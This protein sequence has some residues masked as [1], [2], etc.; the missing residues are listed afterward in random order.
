MEKMKTDSKVRQ[1]LAKASHLYFFGIY[2]GEWA[3][4][5]TA[6]F[7]REIFQIT[8]NPDIPLAVIASFRGSAKSTIVTNSYPIWAIVGKPQKKFVVIASNTQRQARQHLANIKSMLEQNDLL[9]MDL[10]PFQ[11]QDEWGSYS[12]V[13]PQY[14]ARI[15]A[16]SSEQSI[17]GLRHGSSRPDLIIVDDV[18]DL[19]SV[20]TR[21]G[22]DKIY[23]WFS[24]DVIPA[25]E[26]FQT[27]IMVVGNL[28]HE[29][30]LIMRLKQSIK[31][32]RH[33][34]A[35]F[36]AYPLL[37]AAE[38]VAWPDKYKTSADIEL[39]RQIVGDDIAWQREFLLRIVADEG[40]IIKPEW[41]QYYDELP[42][43]KIQ[44]NHYRFAGVGVDLASSQNS[45][46]DY[47]AMVSGKVFGYDDRT[48]IYILPHP[49]NERMEFP[50][51]V[52][53]LKQL[54]SILDPSKKSRLFIEDVQYQASLVQELQSKNYPAEGVKVHGQDK[55]AR[56]VIISH[57][58]KQGVVKFPRKGCEQL[59][60]QL[61]GF[62]VEK[63]D[64]LADAFAIL[65]NQ[66]MIGN[67]KKMAM[68]EVWFCSRS[69]DSDLE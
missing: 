13:L 58:L 52:E 64:D 44:E 35:I 3:K 38:N 6:Q 28:L 63:H 60:Q 48:T 17:R 56:L 36:R 41:I 47:V 67:N 1:A 49:I 61:V 32:G 42:D 20:K 59:I 11:E 26:L 31:E 15:L 53:R 24:R 55:A 62:G 10:G 7:Q 2:F 69:R 43:S 54:S 25:G 14:G 34:G 5:H 66:V 19:E 51:Q 16:A 39:Q 4:Y 65:V 12:L 22:R 29:D 33:S 21:E 30:S 46:A 9:K 37:D 27:K 68:P 8:E 18:E 45:R 50:S 40:Q 23:Q 57:Y